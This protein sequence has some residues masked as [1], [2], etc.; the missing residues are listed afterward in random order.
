MTGTLKEWYHNLGAFKKDELHRLE[1]TVVLCVLH[2]EFIGD[3]EIFDRKSK[4]TR[5]V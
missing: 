1:N 5:I 2:I 4:L 3:M